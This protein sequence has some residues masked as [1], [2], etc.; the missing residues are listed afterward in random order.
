MQA[1]RKLRVD[2]GRRAG[3]LWCC[4][5]LCPTL[6]TRPLSRWCPSN[7]PSC[8]METLTVNHTRAVCI[9]CLVPGCNVVN[10][11]G[12]FSTDHSGLRIN[13]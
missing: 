2:R 5:I 8:S 6:T 4:V 3:S 1:E 12:N 13:K 11:G 9:D 7:L 10:G